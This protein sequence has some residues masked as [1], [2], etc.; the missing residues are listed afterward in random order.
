MKLYWLI[1]KD[2]HETE[3][4][5]I[6]ILKKL[7]IHYKLV[8]GSKFDFNP[9][10]LFNI[11]DCVI[12]YGSLQ[13][14]KK[15]RQS[16]LVPGLYWNEK[17]MLCSNYYSYYENELL[18]SD[19]IMLPYGEISR[20]RDFLFKI[21]GDTLF[22]RPDS[23]NKQF[24]GN[25]L[26]KDNFDYVLDIINIYNIDNDLMCLISPAKNI[27]KEW[28]FVIVNGEV[29]SGSLYRDWTNGGELTE[30]DTKDIVLLK[31][32]SKY[33]LVDENSDVFKYCQK[34]SKLYDADK[35]YTID[36]TLT[37]NNEYKVIEI[38]SFSCAGLYSNDLEKIIK[39]VNEISIDDWNE[40]QEAVNF[41]EV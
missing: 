22:I 31:S 16:N 21:F 2:L 12:F 20:K 11:D 35:A 1:E 10:T 37:D 14:G 6:D 38:G 24:T 9:D 41:F 28:R 8:D 40:Y 36:I 23:G 3:K 39:S 27:L 4:S 15:V 26:N 30:N 19:Y 7:N 17:N 25:L 34:V 32:K 18:H 29:I 13:Y 5:H 33:E